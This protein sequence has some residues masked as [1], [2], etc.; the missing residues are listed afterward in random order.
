SDAELQLGGHP[1]EPALEWDDELKT[2]VNLHI[3]SEPERSPGEDHIRQA[4]QANIGLF[5]GVDLALKGLPQPRYSEDDLPPGVH[6]FELQDLIQRQKWLATLGRSIKERRTVN[7]VWEDVT[8]FS[9]SDTCT[10]SAG[11]DS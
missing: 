8:P 9:A 5:V 6:E 1:W 7:S 11:S 4:F 2:Y 3:F 10:G